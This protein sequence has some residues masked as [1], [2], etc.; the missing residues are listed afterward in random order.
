MP[1]IGI[2]LLKTGLVFLIPAIFLSILGIPSRTGL[3]KMILNK[4]Y[5]SLPEIQSEEGKQT[6]E[7]I[8]ESSITA[9]DIIGIGSWIVAIVS[10]FLGL[11]LYSKGY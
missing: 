7:N 3:Y 1:S 4:F 6:I 10:I 2:N 5:E 11:V 9:L 8:K